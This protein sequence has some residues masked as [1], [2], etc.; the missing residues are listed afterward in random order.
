MTISL[1]DWL[2]RRPKRWAHLDQVP[3]SHL[4][5]LLFAVFL[6][7]SV[8]GFYVDIISGGEQPYAVVAV[9]ATYSGLNAALWIL[10]L[11][12][13]RM[14]WFVVLCLLQVFSATVNIHLSRWLQTSFHLSPV[15]AKV[16]VPFAATCILVAVLVSYVCFVTYIRSAG[17]ESFRLRNEL[18]LAH[19]I[20]KTLV[21]QIRLS[22][23]S[24]EIFGV[25]KPSE[26]VGGDL[27]DVLELPGGDA[28]AY[29]ADIAGHGLQ[30]GILMGMLKTAARTA[31]LDAG[32]YSKE[33]ALSMLMERLNIV[34]PQV[35]EYHMY[36]TFTALR[37]NA[38]GQAFYGMA[39]SPPL[40]HWKA[41][42]G[43][44]IRVQEE[45]FPLGLLAVS[46]FPARQIDVEPGDVI[47]IATDGI[48]E[49]AA[50]DGVEFGINALE[51][52]LT[53]HAHAPLHELASVILK[54]VRVYGKQA[55]DQTLLLVRRKPD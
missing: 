2:L 3:F 38:D 14:V 36:S 22:T 19:S 24:C 4:A 40:L 33:A 17:K 52:L 16:G 30:A 41:A 5:V 9:N 11:A 15:P 50:P 44:V 55:D 35:K 26:K 27:V 37:L 53:T 6:L 7:F 29:L 42:S 46:N 48:Y 8:F 51:N 43:K 25:S 32:S 23:K 39:G 10:V 21:P 45:Q 47:L 1:P 20:Q 28:I 34:L 31:L 54:T 18:A 49:V 12:R 13:L